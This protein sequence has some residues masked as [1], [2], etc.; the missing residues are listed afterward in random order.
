MAIRLR[1]RRRRSIQTDKKQR[2]LLVCRPELEA[3]SVEQQKQI[4]L[5]ILEPHTVSI[6]VVFNVT[7]TTQKPNSPGRCEGAIAQDVGSTTTQH[8]T[9]DRQWRK[10]RPPGESKILGDILEAEEETQLDGRL[11]NA[12]ARLPAQ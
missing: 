7:S 6:T 8:T 5:G 10:H 1:L 12:I 4:L 9:T 2:V 3:T 11:I